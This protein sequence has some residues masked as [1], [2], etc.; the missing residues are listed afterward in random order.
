[1]NHRSCAVLL[2]ALVS[3]CSVN[4]C[5]DDVAD[6]AAADGGDR[7][8]EPTAPSGVDSGVVVHDGRSVNDAGVDRCE[9]VDCSE[10]TSAC[11][12]AHCDPATGG[13]VLEPRSNGQ[14]CDDGDACTD[15]D[16]CTDGKCEGVAIV[17]PPET[18][19]R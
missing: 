16:F 10:Q 13:C 3:V 2:L 5:G 11:A 8:G 12:E 6:D 17:C 7:G 18:P 1:M 15:Q 14:A 9:D 4:A 19:C